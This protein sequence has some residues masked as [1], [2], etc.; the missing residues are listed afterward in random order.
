MVVSLVRNEGVTL[1]ELLAR[2]AGAR[3]HFTFAGTPEQVANLIE[4]WHQNGAADGFNV[5]PPVFPAM[6]DAFIEEVIPILQ[7][8]G[9]FRTTYEGNTLR[10]HYKLDRPVGRFWDND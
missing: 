2:F 3:G 5:M 4:D 10:D 9:L 8:R 1:R 6:L 7:K